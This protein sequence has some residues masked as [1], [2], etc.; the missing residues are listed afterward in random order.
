MWEFIPLVPLQLLDLG[1]HENRFFLIKCI[2][3]VVGF[4][5]INVTSIMNVVKKIQAK[6]LQNNIRDDPLYYG[7]R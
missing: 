4:E 1:G 3:I 5:T 7:Q 6:R 2:R